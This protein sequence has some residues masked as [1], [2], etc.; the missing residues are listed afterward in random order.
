MRVRFNSMRHALR[1]LNN[2]IQNVKYG[3]KFPVTQS[4]EFDGP[5]LRLSAQNHLDSNLGNF[6]KW[7]NIRIGSK[8]SSVTFGR[9]QTS[10][11]SREL[12]AR[13]VMSKRS[14]VIDTIFG[15]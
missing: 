3:R 1:K 11:Y 6:A 10:R 15:Q 7:L 5:Y 4:T 2:S 12:T 13:F 14:R 8:V 9:S